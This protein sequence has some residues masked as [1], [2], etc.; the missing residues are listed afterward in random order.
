MYLYYELH[1]LF[2][3]ITADK[4]VKRCERIRDA[5][6]SCLSQIQNLV[7]VLLAAKVGV[8]LGLFF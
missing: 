7:P 4:V 5:L 1:S 2:K 3:A 6:D 8:A